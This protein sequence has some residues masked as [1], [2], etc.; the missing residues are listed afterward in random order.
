[1]NYGFMFVATGEK[2]RLELQQSIAQLRRIM[3]DISIAVASECSKD[4]DCDNFIHIE[5]P[6]YNFGDK[7]LNMR[8]TPFERTI[9]LDTDTYVIEPIDDLFELLN[10][11]DVAAPMAPIDEHIV[12]IPD[13]FSEFNTGILAYRFN[14]NTE[15]LFQ[16]WFDL[17]SYQLRHSQDG[18]IP[19]DQLSFRECVYLSDIKFGHLSS[20]YNC[21]LDY[22]ILVKD[23]VRVLHAHCSICEFESFSIKINKTAGYRIS[24]PNDKIL[25]LG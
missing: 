19:P 16:N 15:L 17:F 7:V 20:E 5:Q 14:R 12:G 1:M 22:P 25:Y 18:D 21:M 4:V 11:V 2:Y 3:P 24:I 9:F 23:K 13:S 6:M 10:I 8:Y